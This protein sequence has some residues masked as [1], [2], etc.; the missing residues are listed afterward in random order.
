VEQYAKY[1]GGST[2]RTHVIAVAFSQQVPPQ[3]RRWLTEFIIREDEPHVARGCLMPPPD[4]RTLSNSV[5]PIHLPPNWV[6]FSA[7]TASNK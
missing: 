6:T 4:R 1:L 3:G 7:T 5:A 2:D